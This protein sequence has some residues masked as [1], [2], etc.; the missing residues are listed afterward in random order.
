MSEKIVQLNEE[1]IKG[2]IKELVRGSVEE[3]LNEL[4][5]KEAETL[6]QAARY[7]RNEAR[8]GYRSGHYDRNLTTTSGDVTLHVPRL[9]GVSFEMAIIERYR[10]RESSVE[11]ALI[12][13]YLAGVSVLRVE[14][15]TEALWGSKV[16]PATISELNK[17]AY[18][19]IEDWRN[20]PLQGGRYPYVYVDGIYLRRNWGGEYENEDGF[21]EVLGAAEGMKEDKASWINFFQWL[22]GRG[23]D[24]VKLIVGDKCMGMLEAVGE[25]F[26]DA[27]YQRCTVHFYRNVFSVVPKSKVKIVAKMLKAIHAQENKKASREKAKAVVAELRAMKLKEAARRSKTASRKR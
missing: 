17:K 15:I 9:K 6:T 18:V 10:R 19:H 3:T 5:E 24:G 1:V 4:L 25:V 22:R 21:R 23:L 20:R 2:E 12:E 8:Q 27:K 16:S 11:E 7:E 26:P 13:M 14:D